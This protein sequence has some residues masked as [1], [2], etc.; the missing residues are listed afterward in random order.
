M[1]GRLIVFEGVEGCGKTTQIAYLRQWLEESG[2]VEQ[3]VKAGKVS[4]LVTTREPGGTALGQEIRQLL[5]HSTTEQIQ[6]R[7]ELLL[8]AAD[9]AQHVEGV[10]RPG[11]ADGA[12]I[13]C[14][15]YTDSTLAYQGYGRGLDRALI[16]QLNQIATGGLES[17]LTLWLD[18]DVKI[19]L[20]RA[21]QRGIHDRMEQ[22][23]L[24]FHQRVQQGF[25][26][27][28]QSFPQRIVRVDASLDEQAVA[29]QI[30]AIVQQHLAKWYP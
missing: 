10:L 28:A 26:E 13:L 18:V 2:A 8:Y 15:R 20:E 5:L 29:N 21:R 30:Q 11:L 1:Q 16:D 9:R 12:L 6:A 27:L 14:D 22:A 4:K 19:G 7:T 25:M 3:F 17:D 23:T 24:E